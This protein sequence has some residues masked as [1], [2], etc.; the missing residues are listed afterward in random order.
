MFIVTLGNTKHISY[1]NEGHCQTNLFTVMRCGSVV[2]VHLWRMPVYK[3]NNYVDISDMFTSAA[4]S[5]YAFCKHPRKT[6]KFISTSL[7]KFFGRFQ[8]CLVT[9]NPCVALS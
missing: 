2:V 4:S 5:C 3:Y 8:I 1:T 9:I 7:N 6:S